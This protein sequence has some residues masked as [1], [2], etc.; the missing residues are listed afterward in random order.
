MM[1]FLVVMFIVIMILIVIALGM[2]ISMLIAVVV[3]CRLGVKRNAVGTAQVA[4]GH[5]YVAPV[6][7][8]R[9]PHPMGGCRHIGVC[10]GIHFAVALLMLL[11][12]IIPM[13]VVICLMIFVMVGIM[14]LQYSAA[15]DFIILHLG[16]LIAIGQVQAAN[17]ASQREIN[18][19]TVIH[20]LRFSAQVT[21]ETLKVRRRYGV[22]H[23]IDNAAD[24]AV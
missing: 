16:V 11:V 21:T 7:C 5:T 18:G 3:M 17:V 4:V 14:H 8:R 1:R 15:G 10:E 22:I 23:H 13:I 2:L 19:L 6:T 9:E 20:R 12:M 24:G